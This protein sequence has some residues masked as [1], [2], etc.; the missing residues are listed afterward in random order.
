[1]AEAAKEQ[2]QSA[3]GTIGDEQQVRTQARQAASMLRGLSPMFVKVAPNSQVAAGVGGDC[4]Q[5]SSGL[6]AI[7][8]S[9][10][11]G[12]F[13]GSVFRMCDPPRKVAASRIGQL[14]TAMA[15]LL[16]AK[17]PQNAPPQQV[18][19]WAR[20]FETFGGRLIN[21]PSQCDAASGAMAQAREEE[22][23]AEI[24]HQANVNAAMTAATVILGTA[25][26]A[27]GTVAA[28]EASRPIIVQN[29]PVENNYY[30]VSPQPVQMQRV[31][32]PPAPAPI[33][34]P[35]EN[36]QQYRNSVP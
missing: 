17:P 24:Q 14:M 2:A 3:T 32:P 34:S 30:V 25:L 10:T 9:Q 36:L 21:I 33:T 23:Q 15:S 4:A 11:D 35:M 20:Y 22:R 29:P 27:A 26:V 13:T 5:L 28:A 7:A 19:Q 31:G 18:E 1:M 8:D 12:Q 6:D 16:R